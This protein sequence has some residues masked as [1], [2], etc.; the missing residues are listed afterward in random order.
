MLPSARTNPQPPL[1]PPDLRQAT[2]HLQRV[3]R[4]VWSASPRGT[5]LLAA[6]AFSL[7]ALPHL[8]A[9]VT[10]HWDL[11]GRPDGTMSPTVAAL[12]VPLAGALLGAIFAFLPHA[13]PRRE[14]LLHGGIWWT[15]GNAILAFLAVVQVALLGYNLGWP[16]SINGVVLVGVGL[17]LVLLG[18]L[19]PRM[20]PN[21]FMGIRT[22]WTLTSD[23]VWRRTHALGGRVFYHGKP[24][25]AI[26]RSCLAALACPPEKVLMIG[27]S[28]DHDVLGASRAGIASALI[29][30]AVHGPELGV[31]YGELPDENRW[32]AFA[33][34]ASSQ[35]EY[36]LAAFN[37]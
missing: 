12:F 34:K 17:L 25:P 13:D 3:F 5:L 10:T 20:Q 6:L 35:P 15:L 7:W 8:P 24:Y 36:L 27:D 11:A 28:V 18:F 22:P 2:E 14:G 30:G 33:A 4:L 19:M 21:W 32:R 23:T 37:W 16:L 1:R 29:P 9:R 31:A 26:Y